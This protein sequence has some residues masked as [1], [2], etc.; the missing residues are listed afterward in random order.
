MLDS[1]DQTVDVFYPSQL[2]E[3]VGRGEGNHHGGSV[4]PFFGIATDGKRQFPLVAFAH[5]WNGG[6]DLN[7]YSYYPLL[8]ELAS[9]GYVVAAVR[10]CNLGCLDHPRNLPFDPPG[11][12]DYYKQQLGVIEF[13]RRR[14]R[15]GVCGHVCVCV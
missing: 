3:E 12:G 8:S 11:F 7:I 5:G 10:A 1:S 15:L 14:A 13:V 2:K 4:S 6:G 9:Y